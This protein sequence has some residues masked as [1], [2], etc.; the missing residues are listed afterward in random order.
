MSNLITT[1]NIMVG[2]CCVLDNL[3]RMLYFMCEKDGAVVSR[4]M[5]EFQGET[6]MAVG[7]GDSRLDPLLVTKIQETF[8]SLVVSD[9]QTLETIQSLY[10]THEVLL[11][12]H[13]AVG[14]YAAQTLQEGGVLDTPVPDADHTPI[15]CVLTAHPAKFEDSVGEALGGESALSA[16]KA[17]F[18]TDTTTCSA[19]SSG[20]QQADLLKMKPQQYEWLR[21]AS[22]PTS[23]GSTAQVIDPDWRNYW[24]K[25]L[26]TSIITVACS[27]KQ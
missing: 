19:F 25:T 22:T 26:K 7:T 17:A 8:D 13:S 6:G 3:E 24:I 16:A 27:H 20:F 11:C 15:V 1:I 12:P 5:S 2:F 10:Q 9:A 14:A 21:K 4:I 18:A 23:T